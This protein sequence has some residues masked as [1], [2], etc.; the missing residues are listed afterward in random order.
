MHSI[1]SPQVFK[2]SN[3]C[4]KE[5]TQ[6]L[7]ILI[8]LIIKPLAQ[9][10]VIVLATSKLVEIICY[11]KVTA[12]D[13][14]TNLQYKYSF[15]LQEIRLLVATLL[16]RYR[17]EEIAGQNLDMVQYVTPAFKTKTYNVQFYER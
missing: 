3:L 7:L 9:V 1:H 17:L 13:Q 5:S 12:I 8:W 15:A 16:H 2:K 11:F 10:L 14:V 6:A 4:L